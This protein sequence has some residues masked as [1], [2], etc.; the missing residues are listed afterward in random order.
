M[1]VN[2]YQSPQ[3][4]SD[5]G[6]IPPLLRAVGG[7]VLGTLGYAALIAAVFF[8]MLFMLFNGALR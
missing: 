4:A 6:T 7:F 3:E 5:S 1:S 8:A 2:P